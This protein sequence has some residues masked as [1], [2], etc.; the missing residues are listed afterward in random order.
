MMLT[1]FAREAKTDER[2]AQLITVL[3]GGKQTL[4]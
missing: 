2:V 1:T 3:H 4:K